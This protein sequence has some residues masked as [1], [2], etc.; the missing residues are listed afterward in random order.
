MAN[1]QSF[2]PLVL[3]T[4]SPQ[5]IVT[6]TLNRPRQA[7]ALNEALVNE[8]EKVLLQLGTEPADSVK[9]LIL[10]ANGNIF[11]A[12]HD[13]AELCEATQLAKDER[14]AKGKS[15]FE[16]CSRVSKLLAHFAV[17][18]IAKIQGTVTAAGLQLAASC[19]IIVA[20]KTAKFSTA[21]IKVG[22][23]CGTPAVMLSRRMQP[24]KCFE[25]LVTGDTITADEALAAG[26][27]NHAVPPE[28]L[29]AKVLQ[30]AASISLKS[31]IA[32]RQGKSMFYAQLDMP[33]EPAYNLAVAHMANSL[34]TEDVAMGLDSFLKK[35]PIT[36]WKGR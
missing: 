13:I 3:R 9:V 18:V 30:I 23:F 14:L 35:Q 15:I 34:C 12:G 22:L 25:M 5:G 8:L 33:L 17:P 31:P 16:N 4:D 1:L 20:S 6:L 32:I 28:E 11:S 26:L 24:K 2:E 29:D 27:V 21:G 19:D 36:V 7:N 10:C